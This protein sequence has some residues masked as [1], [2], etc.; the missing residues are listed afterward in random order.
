MDKLRGRRQQFSIVGK[1]GLGR[2]RRFYGLSIKNS[3][4]LADMVMET[5]DHGEHMD[6]LKTKWKLE[7][8]EIS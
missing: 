3:T 6:V 2:K 4:F 1:Y 5:M 7:E 8:V